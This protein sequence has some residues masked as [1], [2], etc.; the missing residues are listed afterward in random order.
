M[1]P[2][3]STTG[4]IPEMKINR[5]GKAVE[6]T[7]L[8]LMP[9]YTTASVLFYIRFSMF[10]LLS[11]PDISKYWPAAISSQLRHIEEQEEE[12]EVKRERERCLLYLVDSLS[13]FIYFLNLSSTR[14]VTEGASEQTWSYL[15]RGYPLFAPSSYFLRWNYLNFASPHR[16][17]FIIIMPK[18]DLLSR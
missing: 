5:M 10:L 7:F 6:C 3:F 11:V 18:L 16:G 13:D 9:N 2:S 8:F 17:K 1:L 4:R 14:V 15:G 12:E